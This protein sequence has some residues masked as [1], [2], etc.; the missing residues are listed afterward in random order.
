MSEDD[1]SPTIHVEEF[2][3]LAPSN[4]YRKYLLHKRLLTV[5]GV[6]ATVVLVVVLLKKDKAMTAQYFESLEKANQLSTKYDKLFHDHLTMS[7]KYLDLL[8]KYLDAIG[9]PKLE[10]IKN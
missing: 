9:V 7:E 4:R 2:A 8:E 1:S 3:Q 10:E 5:V 6:S